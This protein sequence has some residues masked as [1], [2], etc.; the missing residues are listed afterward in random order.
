[1]SDQM[2]TQRLLSYYA[3]NFNFAIYYDKLYKKEYLPSRIRYNQFFFF[4]SLAVACKFL[5]FKP[6]FSTTSDPNN[7]AARKYYTT[8]RS[9]VNFFMRQANR[10]T[11]ASHVGK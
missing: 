3:Q 5:L 1:M 4:A 11:V 10:G 7:L 8:D 9:I 6:M 2:K